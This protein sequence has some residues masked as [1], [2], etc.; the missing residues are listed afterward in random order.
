M[1]SLINVQQ[2]SEIVKRLFRQNEQAFEN[3]VKKLE[4][5][6]IWKEAIHIVEEELKKFDVY[7]RDQNAGLFTNILY[8][9][10]FPDDDQICI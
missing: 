2:R 4:P 8:A 3:L 6:T 10:Y 7:I 1:A 9:R 5:I